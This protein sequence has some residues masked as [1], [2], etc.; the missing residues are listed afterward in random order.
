MT[1]SPRTALVFARHRTLALV[2]HLAPEELERVFTPI[3]SPLAWDLGHIAAYEDLWLNHRLAGR[4]LLR[5]DLAELYD[6]FETPRASRGGARFLRGEEL[7]AYLEEVRARALDSPVQDGE[8][9]E[10]VARHELQHTETMLQAL[11]IGNRL[12]PGWGQPGSPSASD[13]ESDREFSERG[14][15]RAA[16]GAGTGSFAFDNERPRHEVSLAGFAI[17]RR[18]VSNATWAAFIDAGGYARRELWTQRGWEWRVATGVDDHAGA[19]TGP[20]GAP[21]VHVSAHEADALARAHGARLPSE[22]EW[23][24]AADEA[25]LEGVGEVWEWTAS[26]F[27]GYP[28]FRAHP[29]REY[30]EVFFGD[31]YRVL[32]GWSCVTAE[33][34]ASVSFRNWD[35]PERRQLFAGVRLAAD[36][37]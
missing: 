19:R 18:P 26:E 10:L 15:A 29:Y 8:I 16:I 9:H 21:V 33:R 24:A 25:L 3:L 4:P 1:D 34:L 28:G 12:P 37:P 13:E 30:S 36:L 27:A 23:E 11:A 20:P 32:R 35:L 31:R 2:A 14:A 5:P 6:A 7:R 17:A 22:F